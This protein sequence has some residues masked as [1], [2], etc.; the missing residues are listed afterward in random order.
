MG[1]P[2]VDVER[3]ACAV[4]PDRHAVE[5]CAECGRPA[6]LSCAVPFRGRVL[7]ASCAARALGEPSPPAR[8]SRRW[9]LPDQVAG[10]LLVVALLLTVPP[11]HRFGALTR[12]L[13]AWRPEPDPWPTAACALLLAAALVLMLPMALRRPPAQLITA[14]SGALAALGALAILRAFLGAPDFYRHTAAP[15]GAMAAGVGVAV[16]S[17]VHLARRRPA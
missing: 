8:P 1:T 6:C 15:L 17:L 10:A 9:G 3:Q 11:W 5:R 2:D 13:S 12:P 14:A 4:H 16:L 7:C